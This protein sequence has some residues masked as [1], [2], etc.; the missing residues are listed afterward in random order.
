L[1]AIDA[2]I[3][4]ILNVVTPGLK[5]SYNTN[6]RQQ[7]P[8]SSIPT[9]SLIPQSHPF[10]RCWGLPPPI[11]TNTSQYHVTG[12]YTDV[13]RLLNLLNKGQDGA[14]QYDE[15][16]GNWNH[17]SLWK[18]HNDAVNTYMAFE[19]EHKH[20]KNDYKSILHVH[21]D[22]KAVFNKL[23]L[24][25]ATLCANIQNLNDNNAQLRQDRDSATER[26]MG[27]AAENEQLNDEILHL[28]DELTVVKEHISSIYEEQG[29]PQEDS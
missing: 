1:D 26:S 19:E 29:W 10:P 4:I 27:L 17:D 23:E 2:A 13:P 15:T 5:K 28:Q 3:Q 9:L 14:P 8:N 20:L 7:F 11:A 25:N 24:L 21:D 16:L 6:L 12:R 18:A 22:L